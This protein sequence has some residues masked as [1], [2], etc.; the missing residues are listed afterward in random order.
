MIINARLIVIDADAAIAFYQAAL[1]ANLVDRM[2]D[3]SGMVVH[4]QLQLEQSEITLSEAV[5]EWGWNSPQTLGG[6][7]VLLHATVEDPDAIGKR[8]VEHGSTIIVPIENRPYGKREGRVQDPFGHLW[9]LSG[10]PR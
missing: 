4:A 2:A 10:D 5:A 6:S 7:P 3:D 8:M 9:I 1:G